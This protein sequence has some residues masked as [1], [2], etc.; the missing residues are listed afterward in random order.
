MDF[1]TILQFA[2]VFAALASAWIALLMWLQKRKAEAAK[3][4]AEAEKARADAIQAGPKLAAALRKSDAEHGLFREID[5]VL[6]AAR[7]DPGLIHADEMRNKIARIHVELRALAI[8]FS[9]PVTWDAG[10]PPASQGLLKGLLVTTAPFILL[11]R[12]TPLTVRKE[13]RFWNGSK[14]TAAKQIY[15]AMEVDFNDA[16][17][18]S[19]IAESE[20]EEPTEAFRDAAE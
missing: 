11:V 14:E 1:L 3:I 10:A 16:L 6:K 2:S 13:W 9:S 5:E 4:K 7:K 12:T 19:S 8:T 20:H 17:K 18:K 15:A